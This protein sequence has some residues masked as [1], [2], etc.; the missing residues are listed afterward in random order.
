MRSKAILA[1]LALATALTTFLAA[2]RP[3]A[4]EENVAQAYP[5]VLILGVFHM[6]N[7]GQ[8]VHNMEADDILSPSRQA[9]IAAVV[10][11]LRSFELT[12]IAVESDVTSKRVPQRYAA[13]LAGEH[14]LTRNETEQLGFRLAAELEHPAVFPVDADGEFPYLRLVKYAQATGDMAAF[15]ALQEATGDR[16]EAEGEYL[17]THSLLE[18][19]LLMNSDERVAE[20][21]GSYFR[22]AEFSEPWD[23]AGPDLVSDWFRRNM[24]IYGNIVNLIDSPNDRVLVIYGAGHLGWL[25]LAFEG[26]PALRLRRLSELVATP[27]P[28][29][30]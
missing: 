15:E 4:A 27:A 10:S 1:S 5:E 14:E 8:D 30:E 16:V 22:M 17:A 28:P 21:V 12:K 24:G 18:M 6:A 7:P 23:W 9:E 26:N 29:A 25:Q 2:T 20:S 19:L 13:Y 11:V 3:T